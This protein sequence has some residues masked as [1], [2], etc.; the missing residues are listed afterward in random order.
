MSYFFASAIHSSWYLL[1]FV[2]SI[3]IAEK[4]GIKSSNCATR[5]ANLLNDTR[6]LI[7]NAEKFASTSIP[8][9]MNA[10]R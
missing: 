1:Y 9:M 10:N 8:F 7:E 5:F 3:C 6:E 2:H 4:N